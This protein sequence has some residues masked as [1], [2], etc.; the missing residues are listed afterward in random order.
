MAR[1]SRR[2]ARA[3][4]AAVAAV[5]LTSFE[6]NA[7]AFAV[8]EQ[9]A[10]GQGMAYAGEGTSSMGLSAMFWNPAA[11]TQT[12]GLQSEAHVSGIFPNS[13]LTTLPGTSAQL[14][15]LG[16]NPVDIGKAALLG[17]FY[18]G[19]QYN[20]SLYL[21]FT[22]STP[23]GLRTL[24][25]LPWSGQNLSLKAAAKSFEGNPIV[26]YRFNDTISAAAGFRV[27]WAKA[28][29]SR[30]I[31]PSA[32][33]PNIASLEATDF[34]FG[35]NA[36][37]TITPWA[38]TELA[39]GYRSATKISLNG[40]TALPPVAPLVGIFGVNGKVT[41]PDQ[42][43]FGIRQSIAESLTLLGT[44]EWQNWSMLQTVPFMFTSCP[45][46]GATATTFAFNYR[47]AWYFSIG[48]E[49]KW[50]PGTTL[51]SGVGYEVAPITDAVRNPSIPSNDGWRFSLGMT[52]E[53]TPA[54]T[55]DAG[56]SYI[57]VKDAP[58]NVVPGHSESGNLLFPAPLGQL[59]Y[60]GRSRLNISM[61]SLGLRYRF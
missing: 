34:G 5:A 12:N 42:A 44:V 29:F 26:A 22:A 40:I 19:Y 49:Y 60:A 4:S 57:A 3:A 47:D 14:L 58:I 13:R 1:W 10:S 36:G 24:A 46:A 38:T 30:A 2:A 11:V 56:Y 61:L 33:V 25:P 35:W 55:L 31:L 8:R 51:R 27:L 20:Q 23:F 28:E 43:H 59:R 7:G 37:V 41:L 6:V 52:H 16:T 9:S 18:A 45:A 15:A 32:F 39:L 48:G 54:I 21:G 17:S 53:I 50:M